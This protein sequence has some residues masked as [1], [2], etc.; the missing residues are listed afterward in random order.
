M[1]TA[2][3][4]AVS[5][6]SLRQAILFG[7]LLVT[8]DVFLLGQGALAL[9]VGICLLFIGLPRTFLARKFVAVRARRLRNIAVYLAAVIAVFLLNAENNRIAR[10]RADTLVSAVNA[11]HAKNQR[12]P[13][14][15]QELVPDHIDRVPLAKYALMFNRF[16]YYTSGQGASL[17]YVELPPFGRP[18]YCFTRNEWGY[19]D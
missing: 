15:L 6:P 7:A 2:E 10:S 5:Q 8:V 19:L 11:F 16:S 14:S 9:L 17:F 18:T 1:T 13:N 12:Y 4:A 3:P